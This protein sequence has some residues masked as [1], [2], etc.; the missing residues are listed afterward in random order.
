M[1]NLEIHF[2]DVG[3]TKYGDCIV[4]RHGANRILI[5]E[6]QPGDANLL[7]GQL[8]TLLSGARPHHFDLVVLT[9]CHQDHI[10][11]MPDLFA[12]GIVTAAKAYLADI[13]LG[14]GTHNPHDALP[15][16]ADARVAAVVALLREENA[17]SLKPA[18]I[19]AALAD[20]ATMRLRFQR[21]IDEIRQNGT[22]IVSATGE[23][24]RA[25]IESEFAGMGLRILGPTKKHLRI[26]ADQIAREQRD[27]LQV[28]N[29]T[30]SIDAGASAYELLQ[31]IASRRFGQDGPLLADGFKEGTALNCQ[32][33]ILSLEFAGK[34]V[35]LG[36]DM[37]FADP[38]VDDIA[39]E[40]AALR[41][42]VA[43]HG[44]FDVVKTCHHTSHNGWDKP[45]GDAIL[46][47]AQH[48]YLVHS[49][50][51]NDD[52]HPA[53]VTLKELRALRAARGNKLTYL[54]TD[55]NGQISFT[56]ATNGTIEYKK[57]RG[58]VNNFQPNAGDESAALGLP[59]A[60]EPKASAPAVSVAG[61][62]VEVITRLPNRKTRVIVTID[63]DPAVGVTTQTGGEPV[64]QADPAVRFA[65]PADRTLP[66]LLFVT[67]E[68]ALGRKIGAGNA[69]AAIAAVTQ[70][71]HALVN[72]NFSGQTAMQAAGR[73]RDA[74][75]DVEGVVLLGG[76]D[77]VPSVRL[78]V[79][80]PDLRPRL[81]D[82]EEDPDNFIVWND[83]I[84]GD[85][86]ND[87]LPELPVSRIADGGSA[88][89]VAAALSAAA[90]NGQTRFGVRNVRRPFA[91]T[92][93][94][95]LA[96]SQAMF[97]SEPLHSSHLRPRDVQTDIAYIMLHGDDSDAR[98]FWG[99]TAG[100][101]LEAFGLDQIP[102]TF[103]G[104]VFAGCCWG[105]L[106]TTRRALHFA[107][108][109]PVA[110]RAAADSIPL[111]FLAAGAQAFVGCTGVHYSPGGNQ[112]TRA[113][114]PMHV[115]FFNRLMGGDPPARALFR[116]KQ[117]CLAKIDPD[118]DPEEVAVS[119]KI[120]RQ[121]TCLGLGW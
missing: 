19:D 117:E 8:D 113:G 20:A 106:T 73:V 4:L 24:D 102:A 34:K 104:V 94:R 55:R 83:E 70:G 92:V 116:A 109:Q 12:R 35:L 3:T 110:C 29:E 120:I 121:F 112:P 57:A 7:G 25:A 33:T 76:V 69:R 27:A 64:V 89:L 119:L 77:V 61:D 42:V 62:M 22:A 53:V 6:A 81:E 10:G 28:L 97:I 21:M 41:Q 75:Q 56:I 17:T 45:L 87:E 31:R 91:N 82:P 5:E 68:A 46:P 93:F 47:P 78:D 40:M 107:P 99:E 39:A 23:E 74:L 15:A 51:V 79:L 32:S 65:L 118:A 48:A 26:C 67:D 80:G 49:G 88:R 18:E 36:G 60:G 50:G 11:C 71:G 30:S 101:L 108:G 38:D 44:P 111:R 98:R 1:A 100:S 37:Q 86:D 59:L 84:Y 115:A 85:R 66:R 14:W 2:L 63:V 13:D 114:G 72:G 103:R 95:E 43:N 96:G 54:R 9:H 105:A 90:H 58:R 52:K 16:P